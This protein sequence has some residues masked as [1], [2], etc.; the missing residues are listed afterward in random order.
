LG[1]TSQTGRLAFGTVAGLLLLMSL[2][3]VT[4]TCVAAQARLGRTLLSDV[5]P[6]HR[7]ISGLEQQRDTARR[8]G[9]ALDRAR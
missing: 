2:P 7:G 4:R 6:A 3:L 8:P 5:P 1:L 9:R